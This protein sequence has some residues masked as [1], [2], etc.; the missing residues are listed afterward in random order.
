MLTYA[1]VCWR[2]L[3]YADAWQV[4]RGWAWFYPSWKVKKRCTSYCLFSGHVSCASLR[5]CISYA[6][7]GRCLTVQEKKMAFYEMCLARL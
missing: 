6:F 2:I 7:K 5:A 1:D 4:G 3:T